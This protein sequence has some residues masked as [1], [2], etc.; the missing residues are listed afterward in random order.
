MT[1]FGSTRVFFTVA[2]PIAQVRAPEVFNRVFEKFDI[3][4]VMV[5]LHLVAGNFE[6]T[7]RALMSAPNVGGFSL[8]IPHKPTAAA[9][10]DRCSDVARVAKAVNAIRADKQ[11]ALEGDLFD[12]AGLLSLL[13]RYQLPYKGKQVLLIGAGGAASAIATTLARSGVAGISIYDPDQ[14]KSRTLA[15]LINAHFDVRASSVDSNGPEGFDLVINASPLGLKAHDP[16]PCDVARLDSSASVVDILMKNQPTPW[17]QAVKARG[18]PA[19]AGFDML[20]LQTPLY[21]D[22][23]GYPEAAESLRR[24]DSTLRELLVPPELRA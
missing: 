22:F 23:F 5:P 11:G 24:D 10:M 19:Q 18:L 2:D 13:E 14:A 12:G 4:A 16:M 7:V 8:S 1:I 21:L 3:D 15:D 17:L 20:I 9:M 6:K